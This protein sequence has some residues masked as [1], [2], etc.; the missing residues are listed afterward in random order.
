MQSLWGSIKGRVVAPSFTFDEDFRWSVEG[1]F[2]AIIAQRLRP[3]HRGHGDAST[4][5]FSIKCTCW[6]T[7]NVTMKCVGD[8]NYD[9]ILLGVQWL[10]V[11]PFLHLFVLFII[12][13]RADVLVCD[14]ARY[15][16]LLLFY[17]FV[18]L[19]GISV[20]RMWLS[21][22]CWRTLNIPP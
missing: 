3:R 5:V 13:Y 2:R 9:C 19:H 16:P 12:L 11:H 10:L 4:C 1:P 7:G 22:P 14:L 6:S 8:P 18:F 20:V 15:S 21:P 17:W